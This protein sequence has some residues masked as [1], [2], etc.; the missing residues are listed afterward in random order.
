L[1]LDVINQFLVGGWTKGRSVVTI[2]RN[3]TINLTSPIQ[4]MGRFK[5]YW[6]KPNIASA[7][8]LSNDGY[9]RL[10]IIINAMQ[11]SNVDGSYSMEDPDKCIKSSGHGRGD[12]IL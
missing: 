4:E 3:S 10:L 8:P 2:A 12:V 6:K 1:N 11:V 9:R 7:T 5:G